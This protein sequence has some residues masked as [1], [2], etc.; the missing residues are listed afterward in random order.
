MLHIT[1]VVQL[2]VTSFLILLLLLLIL[3]QVY[4]QNSVMGHGH[5]WS[6]LET[7][8][9]IF[10]QFFHGSQS[11]MCHLNNNQVIWWFEG[12]HT[13]LSSMNSGWLQVGSFFVVRHYR[14]FKFDAE[15]RVQ[16]YTIYDDDDAWCVFLVLKLSSHPALF[17]KITS[18]DT[19]PFAWLLPLLLYSS[20]NSTP[21]WSL[22]FVLWSLHLLF[23]CLQFLCPE[24]CIYKSHIGGW[25]VVAGGKLMWVSLLVYKSV[26]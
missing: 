15:V 9:F 19:F 11:K 10:S 16:E 26:A 6:S 22:M 7:K 20:S 24:S 1:S 18:Y 4:W 2:Y 23:V 5:F 3:L 21:I 17:P 25:D 14:L 13:G 12:T 8:H